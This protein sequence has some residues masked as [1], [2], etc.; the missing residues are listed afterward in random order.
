MLVVQEVKKKQIRRAHLLAE[1]IKYE[2]I[3]GGDEG[4]TENDIRR[5]LCNELEQGNQAAMKTACNIIH[6]RLDELDGKEGVVA[7]T[8]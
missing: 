5:T 8:F 3:L 2:A 1:A 4:L 6:E 7:S